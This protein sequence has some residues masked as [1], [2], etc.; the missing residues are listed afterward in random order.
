MIL[1]RCFILEAL[2]IT[3]IEKISSPH[4]KLCF[5]Y[6]ATKSEL[7]IGGAY[8]KRNA[9]FVINKSRKIKKTVSL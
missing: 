8:I 2:L 3:E 4:R 5:E 7:A 9:V 1:F 6:N